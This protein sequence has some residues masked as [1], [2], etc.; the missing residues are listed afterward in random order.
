M[1][2]SL[3]VTMAAGLFLAACGTE[4][5]VGSLTADAGTDFT[6]AVGD[7]PTFDGCASSG[8]ISNYEWTIVEGPAADDAGKALRETMGSCD[9]D[10]E[11]AMVIDDV[12]E[13][14]I[15]LNIT[16]GNISATDEVVVTV[17]E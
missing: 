13:W 12:G 15:E 7:V 10:L 16:D 6:V 5:E 4:V 3:A 14:T 11:N 9:F 2:R 8:D 1:R 17:T